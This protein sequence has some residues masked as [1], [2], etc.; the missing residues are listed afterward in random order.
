[1]ESKGV[2]V[3]QTA[4]SGGLRLSISGPFPSRV[5]ELPRTSQKRLVRA[6]LCGPLSYRAA[7]KERYSGARNFQ[8]EARW[9]RAFPGSVPCG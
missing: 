4:V 7:W 2:G 9:K 3:A 6:T 8:S 5:P 1:V